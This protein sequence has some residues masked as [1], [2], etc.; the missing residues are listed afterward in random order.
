MTTGQTLIKGAK[1]HNT[2]S[3]NRGYVLAAVFGALAGGLAVALATRA[4]PKMM[5]QMMSGMMQNMMA[6][7]GEGDCDP[8]EM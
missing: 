1:M 5:S 3:H 7:M 6:Q 2:S 4:I 8:A